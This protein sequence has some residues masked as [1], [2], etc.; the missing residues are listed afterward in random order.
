MYSVLKKF[1][2]RTFFILTYNASGLHQIFYDI[3]ICGINPL[4]HGSK[5]RSYALKQICSL[6]LISTTKL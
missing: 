5:N 4:K 2:V 3:A 6:S 1:Q